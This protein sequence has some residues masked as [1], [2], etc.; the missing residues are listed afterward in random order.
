MK[1]EKWLSIPVAAVLA[2]GISFGVAGC[3][4]GDFIGKKVFDKLDSD[5]LKKI[6]YIGMIISGIVMFF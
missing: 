3:L 6:I 5:K 4:V 2:F 1:G